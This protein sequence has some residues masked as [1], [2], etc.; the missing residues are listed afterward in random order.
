MEVQVQ[1][2]PRVQASLYEYV[3]ETRSRPRHKMEVRGLRHAMA[4]LS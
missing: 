2:L 4:D 1:A 3:S